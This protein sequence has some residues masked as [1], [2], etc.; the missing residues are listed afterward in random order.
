MLDLLFRRDHPYVVVVLA[1]GT[2][3]WRLG[4]MGKA[5]PMPWYHT[6]GPSTLPLVMDRKSLGKYGRFQ[7]TMS[8]VPYGLPTSPAVRDAAMDSTINRPDV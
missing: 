5:V 3:F 1:D 4:G 6:M 2:P 7:I 8:S